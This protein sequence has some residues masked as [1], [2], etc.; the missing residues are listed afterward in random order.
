MKLHIMC[1]E[2]LEPRYGFS[3]CYSFYRCNT[4]DKNNSIYYCG[5]ATHRS[6]DKGSE[7]C[8]EFFNASKKV[9]SRNFS[10]P[11]SVHDDCPHIEKIWDTYIGKINQA[12]SRVHPFLEIVGVEDS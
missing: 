9:E 6:P 1:M 11:I 2:V 3:W 12:S 8:D 4:R 10:G 5:L 7:K